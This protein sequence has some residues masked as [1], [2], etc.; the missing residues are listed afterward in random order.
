MTLA[1]L[2][3]NFAEYVYGFW[4]V[5]IVSQW[6][7][8]V[9]TRAGQVH[10]LLTHE[11]GL[12]GT[13]LH[14]FIPTID[15][16]H[17]QEA[18]ADTVLT[19]TQVHETQDGIAVSFSFAIRWSVVDAKKLFESIHE[20]KETLINEVVSSAGGLIGTID[21]DDACVELIDQVE[22]DIS[23]R[24]GEWGVE[25]EALHLANFARART[26]RLITGS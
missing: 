19:P 25:I 20:P 13:G 2:I 7:Q 24:L 3:A 18:N 12:F 8:G 5:R 11:N 9:R 17:T 26:V 15:E 14:F 1:E 10:A 22:R 4:P 6:E 16:V 23:D 21:Y